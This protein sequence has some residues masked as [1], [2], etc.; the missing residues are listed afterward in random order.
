MTNP[1]K[2]TRPRRRIGCPCGCLNPYECRA[3]PVPASDGRGHCC[4]SL[5]FEELAACIRRKIDCANG[6]VHHLIGLVA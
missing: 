1:D 2:D 4:T 5:G 3:I 6:C